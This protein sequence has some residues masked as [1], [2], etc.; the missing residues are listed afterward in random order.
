MVM[1]GRDIAEAEGDLDL[2]CELGAARVNILS[3]DPQRQRSFDQLA[4][5]AELA[6]KRQLEATVEFLPGM[7][8]GDLPTAAEAVRQSG[9][10]NFRVLVDFMHLMRS[11]GSCAEL[12]KLEPNLIGYAQIC[13]VPLV[14]K[15]AQYSDEARHHRLPPGEGELPLENLLSVLPRQITVGIE[16]PMLDRAVAGEGPYERLLGS[17][18]ATRALL[19]RRNGH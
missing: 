17:V 10:P 18:A 19:R 3:L 1:P 11:G 4:R 8:I 14:S 5:F 15:F 12:A 16:V 6:G 2:M 9:L 7:T 13:D